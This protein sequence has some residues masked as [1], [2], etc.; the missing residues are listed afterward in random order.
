MTDAA[1]DTRMS[2]EGIH[3]GTAPVSLTKGKG[4]EQCLRLCAEIMQAEGREST[5]PY[6]WSLPVY[7][8]T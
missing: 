3:A 1:S 8:H 4:W 2:R 6:P 5:N 7:G